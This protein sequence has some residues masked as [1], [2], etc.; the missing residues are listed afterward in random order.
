MPSKSKIQ[1][2]KKDNFK[3]PVS[4]QMGIQKQT[5]KEMKTSLQ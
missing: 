5:S 2:E 3:S 1:K 4:K